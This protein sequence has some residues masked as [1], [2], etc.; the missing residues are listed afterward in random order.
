ML[1]VGLRQGGGTFRDTGIDPGVY[2]MV[3]TVLSV[4]LGR[5]EITENE[6]SQ[7]ECVL[8]VHDYIE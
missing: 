5:M 7:R 6:G 1:T 3:A 8:F 4:I 2:M